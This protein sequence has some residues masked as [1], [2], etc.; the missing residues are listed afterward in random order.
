MK[1][2]GGEEWIVM[3][4][5]TVVFWIRTFICGQCQDYTFASLSQLDPVA[6]H[7]AGINVIVIAPGS[8]KIIKR[9]REIFKCPF[10]IYVD[11]SRRLY[12]LMGM[13][14]LSGDFGPAK[15]R[16]A[17]HQSTI[18]R[19][20]LKGIGNSLFKMPLANPGKISQLGGEFVLGPGLRCDFAHRMTTRSDHLEAPDVLQYA[21][22][23][24]CTLPEQH[25][26]EL[27]QEEIEDLERMHL[28]LEAW[29]NGRETELE[30]IKRR[31]AERR[32]LRY[33]ASIRSASSRLPVSKEEGIDSEGHFDDEHDNERHDEPPVLPLEEG[34]GGGTLLQLQSQI[35]NVGIVPGPE[36][37]PS[38]H[39]GSQ[40]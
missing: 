40:G 26:I 5:K 14:K 25:A 27:A 33:E 3:G 10:P 9:Y 17:Y 24:G 36:R 39:E 4:R 20:I 22:C 34:L 8:W 16:A 38:L 1:K 29:R 23:D 2:I 30:R 19:Q 31:K 35:N 21:G 15:G 28:E 6:I 18:P 13:T 37:T 12:Q 7:E 11:D 32:G